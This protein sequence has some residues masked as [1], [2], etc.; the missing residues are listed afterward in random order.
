[1]Y[2]KASTSTHLEEL[3]DPQKVAEEGVKL[4]TRNEYVS[5]LHELKDEIIRAWRASDRVTT[6]KL[7]IKVIFAN[8]F[9]SY[10]FVYTM[11]FASII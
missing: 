8:L 11:K 5:R 10:I 3:E 6:L 4:I 1:M 2:E 9:L 7:S